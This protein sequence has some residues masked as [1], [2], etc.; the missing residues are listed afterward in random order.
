[1]EQH[2]LSQTPHDVFF[3]PQTPLDTPHGSDASETPSG[4]E[5]IQLEF[6]IFAGLLLQ[7]AT[8]VD[9]TTVDT[10]VLVLIEL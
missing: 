6:V 9:D 5:H 1:M 4:F 7:S 2:E 8:F 3:G 10:F